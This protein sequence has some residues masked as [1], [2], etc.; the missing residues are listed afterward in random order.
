VR[1]SN[2]VCGFALLLLSLPATGAAAGPAHLVADLKTG[3]DPFDPNYGADFNSYLAVNGRVVFLG[4][5]RPFGDCGLWVADAAGGAERLADLCGGRILDSNSKLRMDAT[6]GSRAWFEDLSGVLWRT[7]GTGAGTYS[8]GV[9]V[10]RQFFDTPP[11][12][13]PDGKTLF[14]SGCSLTPRYPDDCEPW[15][16]DGTLAGTRQIRDISPGSSQPTAFA[17]QGGRVLFIADGG[18]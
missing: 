3:S 11:V 17:P 9:R 15:R 2:G 16:S 6:A 8:L 18:L 13:G 12:L 14:F 10:S 5:L 7:D 4:F 1:I